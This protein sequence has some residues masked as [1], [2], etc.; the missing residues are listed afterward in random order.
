MNGTLTIPEDFGIADTFVDF[1]CNY[2]EEWSHGAVFVN[3]FNIGRYHKVDIFL[4]IIT[5]VH[6][7]GLGGSDFLG[8]NF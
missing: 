3:N 4:L 7:S 2:C 6:L 8:P 5:Y 1:G